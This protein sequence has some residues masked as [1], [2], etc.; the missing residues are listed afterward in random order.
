MGEPL[1]VGGKHER[2]SRVKDN[3]KFDANY[4]EA[5]GPFIP[6][7]PVGRTSTRFLEDGSKEVKY[8]DLQLRTVKRSDGGLFVYPIDSDIALAGDALVTALSLLQ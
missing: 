3:K 2:Y 1:R 6:R 5:F 7:K 4:A 8:L